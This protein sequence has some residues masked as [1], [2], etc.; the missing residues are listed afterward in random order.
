MVYIRDYLEDHNG[1]P[2][3]SYHIKYAESIDGINCGEIMLVVYFHLMNLKRQ[4]EPC[5]IKE[6]GIYKMWYS[7]RI[8][9][10]S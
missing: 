4:Q 10:V 3:I 1:K 5:V 8:L 2:E 6:E 9:M 7:K